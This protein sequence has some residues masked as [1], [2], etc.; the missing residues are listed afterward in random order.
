M[1]SL[2]VYTAQ[3][4]IFLDFCKMLQVISIVHDKIGCSIGTVEAQKIYA[5]NTTT[6]TVRTVMTWARHGT[7]QAL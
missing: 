2:H 5:E 3:V 1:I 4:S 7:M 6:L